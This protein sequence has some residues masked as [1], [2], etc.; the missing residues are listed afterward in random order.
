MMP[1]TS[2]YWGARAWGAVSITHASIITPASIT[3]ANRPC[4]GTPH[5]PAPPPTSGGKVRA[6]RSKAAEA[7]ITWA[8]LQT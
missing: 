1:C 5:P 2:W 7:P 6:L 3:S 4:I 8:L